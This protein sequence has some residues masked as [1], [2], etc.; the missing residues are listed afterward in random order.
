[1]VKYGEFE[2]L[3]EIMIRL[4]LLGSV[5]LALTGCGDMG[6]IALAAKRAGAWAEHAAWR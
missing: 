5:C 6:S 1:M 4:I 2:A 3:E